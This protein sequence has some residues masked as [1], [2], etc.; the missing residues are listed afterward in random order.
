MIA[1]IMFF[2]GCVVVARA[3][4]ALAALLSGAKEARRGNHNH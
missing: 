1:C 4:V 2:A 3:L